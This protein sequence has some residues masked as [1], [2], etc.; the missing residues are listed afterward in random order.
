MFARPGSHFVVPHAAAG[1]VAVGRGEAIGR[2]IDHLPL[3]AAPGL[4][5]AVLDGVGEV[6]ELTIATQVVRGAVDPLEADPVGGAVGATRDHVARRAVGQAVGVFAGKGHNDLA[7]RGRQCFLTNVI[8]HHCTAAHGHHHELSWRW[9]Q[10][11]TIS[12]D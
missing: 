10:D 8:K 6:L 11:T 1:E 5:P 4:E 12:L 9:R 3:H 7:K 2:V